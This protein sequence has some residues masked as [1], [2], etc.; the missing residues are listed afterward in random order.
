MNAIKIVGR[1]FFWE[2][3]NGTKLF[4]VILSYLL[5]KT[6]IAP[7]FYLQC[8]FA[9]KQKK[10]MCTSRNICSFM[11]IYV[12]WPP[13]IM[14]SLRP[15]TSRVPVV[16]RWRFRTDLGGMCWCSSPLIQWSW[17]LWPYWMQSELMKAWISE[18]SG[19]VWGFLT[20]LTRGHTL[21]CQI[22]SPWKRRRL[23]GT[24]TDYTFKDICTM[25]REPTLSVN[26]P[27]MFLQYIFQIPQGDKN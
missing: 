22:I 26:H 14:N 25:P 27:T 24:G 9:W 18:S 20:M 13:W 12:L 17:Y 6:V 4:L 23:K 2:L 7:S 16:A 10:Y 21:G 8:Y 3:F 15:G 5:C 19:R 1:R 11:S